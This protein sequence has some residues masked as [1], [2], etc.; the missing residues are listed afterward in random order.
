MKTFGV[1]LILFVVVM[2]AVYDGH[3]QRV[4]AP[5]RVRPAQEQVGEDSIERDGTINDIWFNSISDAVRLTD[6]SHSTRTD[7]DNAINSGGDAD[8]VEI[9]MLKNDRFSFQTLFINATGDT[10]D[11]LEMYVDSLSRSGGGYTIKNDSGRSYTNPYWYEGKPIKHWI[12]TYTPV[13]RNAATGDTTGYYDGANWAGWPAAQPQPDSMF[14]GFLPSFCV[15]IEAT[16]GVYDN[17][18]GGYPFVI[19][20]GEVQS[21]GTDLYVAD[22]AVA[23]HYYGRLR[24]YEGGLLTHSKVVHLEVKNYALPDSLPFLTNFYIDY[25]LPTS[26]AGNG[27]RSVGHEQFLDR[28]AM[29]V[30]EHLLSVVY[31]SETPETLAA[32]RGKWYAHTNLFFSADSGYDGV[33]QDWPFN[34]MFIGTYDMPA[35]MDEESDTAGFNSRCGWPTTH[36]ETAWKTNA[37]KWADTMEAVMG[38]DLVG[39]RTKVEF[40]GADEMDLN[41]AVYNWMFRRTKWTHT[42][43]GGD[44]EDIDWIFT[45]PYFDG[46]GGSD[47]ANATKTEVD[48]WSMTGAGGIDSLKGYNESDSLFPDTYFNA[49]HIRNELGHKAGWYNMG[50]RGGFPNWTTLDVPKTESRA[51]FWIAWKYGVDHLWNWHAWYMA[52]WELT[53]SASH[54]NPMDTSIHVFWPTAGLTHGIQDH[55]FIYSLQDTIRPEDDRG[56][57]GP[58]MGYTGKAISAG[59]ADYRVLHAAEA[60]SVNTE[61]VYDSICGK[62]FNDWGDDDNWPEAYSRYYEFQPHWRE[63]GHYYETYR[64]ALIDSII[65]RAS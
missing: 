2:L 35:N 47:D 1:I 32:Y 39:A 52:E 55:T 63:E 8:T 17:G 24:C 23:G 26:V 25:S 44:S 7:A 4:F 22:D 38:H 61:A 62:A 30:K 13:G 16:S 21:I 65:A 59:V 34:W 10:V 54:C 28:T 46:Y 27:D 12:M 18:N 33:G 5:I 36:N 20:P 40:Y 31:Q 42:N 51:A 49:N 56:V 57:N 3:C 50:P 48:H 14:K 19:G 6:T 9:V 15:P 53:Q 41:R 60:L 45:M 58:L 29:L 11:S 43:G 64:R 37:E